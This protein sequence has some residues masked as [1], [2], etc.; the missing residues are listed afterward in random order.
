M[1]LEQEQDD[2]L[3]ERFKNWS[4]T[5]SIKLTETFRAN[6]A[7]YREII[8][9]AVQADKVVREKFES[10]R[11]GIELLSRGPSAMNEAIP[12]AGSSGIS[13]SSAAFRKLKQLMEDVC[14]L[15]IYLADICQVSTPCD[16][17]LMMF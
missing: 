5:P 12:S 10:H 15:S 1:K 16:A 2:Q 14:I 7:K 8:N 17:L 13:S 6:L 11:Q 3:R 4:R 9:N